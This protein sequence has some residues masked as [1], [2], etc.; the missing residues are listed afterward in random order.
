MAA[1]VELIASWL[2]PL[3]IALFNV[4]V[5]GY[6]LATGRSDRSR[7]LFAIGPAGVGLWALAWF[8]S[9]FEVTLSNMTRT[10]GT[11]G[12]AISIVGFALD[13]F[14]AL[15]HRRA[16]VYLAIG[17]AL[18][19]LA[20]FAVGWMIV[21]EAE[22]AEVIRFGVRAGAL[23]LSALA[24]A[25]QIAILRTKDETDEHKKLARAMIGS[26]GAAL[27]VCGAITIAAYFSDRETL[28]DP[29]LFIV[30][31]SELFALVY[32]VRRR[33]EVH[34]LLSRAVTY[35][36]LSILI[37]ALTALVFY[38]LGYELEPVSI[39]ATVAIALMA[40]TLFMGV[41]QKMATAVE[42]VLFPAQARLE[43]ALEASKSELVLLRRRLERVERLAIAGEL[44]A[45]VAHEIKNPLAPIRGYAQ[46]LSGKLEGVEISQR[47]L[48]QKALGI[49]REES[50]RIDG[51]ITE[52][53]LIARGDRE[54]PPI[55]DTLE[56]NRIVLEAIAVAEGE[57]QA[58]QI[59]SK[60]DPAIARVSGNADEIRGALINLIK[61]AVE[62]MQ[63]HQGRIEVITKREN[64][65]AIVEVL[66]EGPGIDPD[67]GERVFRAF[68]TTKQ[69]GTGLGLAIARTAV[70]AAG[71]SI[72]L[73][74]RS[75][76]RGAVARVE[77]DAQEVSS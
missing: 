16:R 31:L 28:V 22:T 1:N 19:G 73:V 5:A 21:R 32:I 76:R 38:T 4:L 58:P 8:I 34:V 49:I 52:L 6:A 23:S 65:R 37:A 43:R 13:S 36:V 77:L 64:G 53:L 61:N 35:A 29:L 27:A 14:L 3:L 50:D 74:P 45:S 30:L 55:D 33:V 26:F 11:V 24:C 70:E 63:G 71:G 75:D 9:Q 59:A 46:L 72:A 56:L 39:A 54:K 69:G 62:A 60:I 40:S 15:T 41:S 2:M 57:P 47:P 68:Y 17:A 20:M 42:G 25:S 10:L 44:A 51:R 12:G 66:D 67:E 18:A 7:L 48:F